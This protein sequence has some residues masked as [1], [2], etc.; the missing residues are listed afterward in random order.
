MSDI[1]PSVPPPAAPTGV[2]VSSVQST[3]IRVSWEAVEDADR[4]TVTFTQTRGEDQLGLCTSD[5]HTS[6]VL[7]TT[8]SASITVGHDVEDG[9]QLRAYT[10]YS[11]TVV[12]V[13]DRG[14]G[15]DSDPITVTTTQT[16]MW[17]PLITSTIS[18]S[19][20]LYR[21]CSSS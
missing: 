17:H 7:A 14:S 1:P 20:S 16:S 11:I 13:S 8:T 6:T 2:S 5:S 4:Y 15:G 12:A 9:G 19:L 10:T 3:T 21:C 18:L